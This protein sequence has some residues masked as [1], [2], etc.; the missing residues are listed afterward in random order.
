[1]SITSWDRELDQLSKRYI[2][3]YRQEK[4]LKQQLVAIKQ[5]KKQLQKFLKGKIDLEYLKT[6]A[7]VN[8]LKE[9]ECVSE[10]IDSPPTKDNLETPVLDKPESIQPVLNASNIQLDKNIEQDISN[11]I[12]SIL[13]EVTQATTEYF[14]KKINH[15]SHLIESVLGEYKGNKWHLNPN[16]NTWYVTQ[17]AYPKE[18]LEQIEISNIKLKDFSPE[19]DS[20]EIIA[21]DNL[22]S[23]PKAAAKVKK[24]GK[25]SK[26]YFKTVLP[27]SPKINA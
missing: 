23:P 26:Q 27:S 21:E 5:Q 13:Q 6:Q 19:F 2:D 4:F 9:L 15:P 18:G 1:M 14:V 16:N 17:T 22:D 24:I 11:L 3:V 25:T 20:L 12:E 10:F 8:T 7:Q